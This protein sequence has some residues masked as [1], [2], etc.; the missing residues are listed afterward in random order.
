MLSYFLYKP[1]LLLG[2]F[3]ILQFWTNMDHYLH[4]LVPFGLPFFCN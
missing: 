1:I 3:F 2:R 4:M